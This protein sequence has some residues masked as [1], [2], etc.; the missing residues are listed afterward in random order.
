MKLLRLTLPA[1]IAVL[2]ATALL[3]HPLRAQSRKR[4][5]PRAIAVLAS[6]SGTPNL[7]ASVLQPVAIKVNGRWYDGALYMANPTPEAVD[8]EVQYDV[9][10]SGEPIGTFTIAETFNLDRHWYGGGIF[11]P[12]GAPAVTISDGGPRLRTRPKS[13]SSGSASASAPNS[14]DRPRLRRGIAP[15]PAMNSTQNDATLAK[16]DADPD[17]PKLRKQGS[18]EQDTQTTPRR[19]FNPEKIFNAPDA[20]M[21][22]AVSDEG[23]PEARS[24]AYKF[25]AGEEEKLQGEM[26][27]LARAELMKSG[28]SAGR[29]EPAAPREVRPRT[30]MARRGSPPPVAAKIDLQDAS[31]HAWDVNSNNA[32]VMVYSATAN[33][34]GAKKYVTVVAWEEIDQSTRRIFARVTDDAH[35]DVYP[36]LGVIDAVD[37]N[38][39][40]RGD[41]LFRAW[42]DEGSHFIIYHP[43]PDA[44]DV[45]FDNSTA[46]R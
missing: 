29:S 21:L 5:T 23:G 15:P 32:P 46:K 20:V 6:A 17:R 34:N 19:Q 28:G 18:G 3:V 37:A 38:G 9:L 25:S 30:G 10:K 13:T 27:K 26:E 24:F 36:R 41:L 39:T 40:G 14:D 2:L 4:N 12:K 31:F 22:A 43:A 45:V 33:L 1:A 7:R 44:L 42:D 16:I 11:Q 35:L 8:V